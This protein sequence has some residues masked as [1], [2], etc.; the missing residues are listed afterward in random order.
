VARL[1]I[2]TLFAALAVAA[3]CGGGGGTEAGVPPADWAASVCGAFEGWRLS[4]EDQA[5][6]LSSEVLNAAT[7]QAAKDRVSTF[8]DEVIASTETLRG[9]IEKVGAPA[10]DQGGAIQEDLNAGLIA[11]ETAFEQARDSVAAV[12]TDDPQAFQ[13]ALTGIGE[14]L[15]T[16]GEQI[17]DTLGGLDEKYD[18][19]ELEAAL[20]NSPGC[21]DIG[22]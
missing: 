6:G 15:E 5:Q 10:V 3:G 17:G 9:E 4:L 8:L 2:L 12:P 20:E 21:E 11:M 18:A 14:A 19:P 22:N 16:Q 7:P 13:Q 1:P